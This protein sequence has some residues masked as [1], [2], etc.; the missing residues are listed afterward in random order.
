M[1]IQKQNKL[2]RFTVFLIGLLLVAQYGCVDLSAVRDFAAISAESAQ[3]TK[4][5]ND[6]VSSPER[7]KRYQPPNQHAT[8]D[9]EKEKR[10]NQK[11]LLLGR[12]AI[13][14]EYTEALGNLASDELVNYDKDIDTLGKAVTNNKFA[15]EKDADAAAAISKILVRAVTDNWRKG[16][17]QELI[18]E[19]NKNFQT[20]IGAL[21]DIVLGG[22]SM[23]LEIESTALGK[24]YMKNIMESKDPAGI[25]ALKEWQQLRI[26]RLEERAQAIEAFSQILKKISEGHQNLYDGRDDLDRDLLIKE[27][28]RYSKDLRSLLN[29]IK[30]L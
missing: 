19:S 30:S 16:K 21:Q 28:R 15:G 5:V 12:H 10:K 13:I 8:L 25:A 11:D 14:Q 23:D 3:Y 7:Q 24:Y 18:A 9:A 2:S 4:L 26:A 6:Y 20:A 27:I 29:T 17:I 1:I 22:F